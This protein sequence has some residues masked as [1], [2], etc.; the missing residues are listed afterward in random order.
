VRRVQVRVEKIAGGHGGVV[1]GVAEDGFDAQYP[2]PYF[3][4][5]WLDPFG[6]MLEVVCLR[7]GLAA[8]AFT[9]YG[10]NRFSALRKSLLGSVSLP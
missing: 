6:V 7:M 2:P 10:A 5:F 8:A 9:D 3:A 1:L 4:M